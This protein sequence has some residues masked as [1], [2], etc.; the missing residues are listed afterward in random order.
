MRAAVAQRSY[1]RRGRRAACLAVLLLG[2]AWPSPAFAW[3]FAAHRAIADQAIARL[4][5]ELQ[6]IFEPFRQ[7]FV[8][9]SLDPDTWRTA[10]FDDEASRHYLDLDWEGFGPY[11]FRNLPRDY[12]AA[13]AA[14]GRERIEEMG[15]LPWR[16]EEFAGRLQRAFEVHAARGDEGS[17]YDIILFSAWLTHYVSDAHV[18]FHAVVNYDGQLTGQ[19]GIHA[20]FESKLFER[21]RDRLRIAPEPLAAV[22][23]P[24]DVVFERLAEGTQ[25]A[26][27]ILAADRDAGFPAVVETQYYDAFYEAVG[28]ILERLISESVATVAAGRRL[29]SGAAQAGVFRR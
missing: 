18:P 7:T 9:R 11:P 25:V 22:A 12:D 3:G 28:P 2:L 16:V 1:P 21:Y 15:T 14:F 17:Q 27:T 26:S 24:R 23:V 4:P 13:V 8:G 19:R 6:A 29:P 10:G 20:R 5:A